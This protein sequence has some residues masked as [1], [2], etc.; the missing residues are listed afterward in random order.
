MIPRM[1]QQLLRTLHRHWTLTRQQ[2]RH[3]QRSLHSF[4]LVLQYLTDEADSVGFLC[5]ED[6]RGKT[7]VFDPGVVADD[8][9][10]A[11]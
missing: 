1:I 6:S 4:L 7:D 10:E 3:L 11:S 5:A 2:L 9:G 8:F